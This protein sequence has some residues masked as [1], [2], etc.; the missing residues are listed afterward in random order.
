[1]MVSFAP[2]VSV[3]GTWV[4]Q[5]ARIEGSRNSQD[6]NEWGKLKGNV[7]RGGHVIYVNCSFLGGFYWH[8]SSYLVIRRSETS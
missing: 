7:H 1:M 8:F 4:N 5:I 3:T 6:D 2:W